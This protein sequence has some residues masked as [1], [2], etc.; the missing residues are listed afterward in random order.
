M[1]ESTGKRLANRKHQTASPPPYPPGWR[2]IPSGKLGAEASLLPS[3]VYIYVIYCYFSSIYLDIVYHTVSYSF[4]AFIVH[5]L[6]L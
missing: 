6:Y 4:I 3:V 1:V 5:I 2:T